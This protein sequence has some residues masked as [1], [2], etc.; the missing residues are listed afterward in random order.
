MTTLK[1]SAG[2]QVASGGPTITLASAIEVESYTKIEFVLTDKA[3]T[4]TITLGQLGTTIQFLVIKADLNDSDAVVKPALTYKDAKGK[5]NFTLDA[6]HLYMGQGFG[7]AL[8]AAGLDFSTLEFTFTPL[9][10]QQIDAQ[11]DKNAVANVKSV[12]VE[13][14]VGGPAKSA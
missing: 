1:V 12:K 13:I 2:V 3:P 6:P 7:N 9:T 11:T 8:A 4:K 10:Q 14:L 5:G